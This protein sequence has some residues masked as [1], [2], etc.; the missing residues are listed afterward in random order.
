MT[1]TRESENSTPVPTFEDLDESNLTA[2]DTGVIQA[3]MEEGLTVF[4]FDGLKRLVG[5]H[6]EKL[7]RIIDRLEEEGFVEKVTEGYR[8]TARGNVVVARPMGSVQPAMPIVQ[9]LLPRDV[10]LESILSQLKG[11]WFG[12]LRWLGYAKNDDGIV[13]KWIAE[14]DGFQ[15]DAKFTDNYLSIDA[16]IAEAGK[17]SEAVKAAHLLLGHVS[18]SY[19]TPRRR[20]H[21]V[22]PVVFYTDFA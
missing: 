6:Q 15:I 12:K 22:S 10:D 20:G 1:S 18:R 8:I 13:L 17:T 4:T 2:R 5:L 21:M 16:K 3:I 11:R 19:T 14:E 9:S 7:S